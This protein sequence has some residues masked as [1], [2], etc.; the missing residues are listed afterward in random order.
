MKIN[1]CGTADKYDGA[2]LNL[3]L[4]RCNARCIRIERG[5]ADSVDFGT[6]SRPTDFH[7]CLCLP[8]HAHEYSYKN[9]HH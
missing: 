2:L 3:P 9:S 5:S 8:M 7:V 1:I 4:D 6:G